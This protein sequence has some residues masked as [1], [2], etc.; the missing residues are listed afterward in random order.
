MND[1][2]NP[3]E[4][5][6]HLRRTQTSTEELMWQWLR[7]RQVAGAK[8]RRQ[9]PIGPYVA[10]FYCEQSKLVI[11]CDGKDHFTEEGANR[12]A[13]RDQYLRERGLT[14]FRFTNQEIE[15]DA[16]KV[17]ES[18]AGWLTKNPSPPA[19]SDENAEK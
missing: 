12:D 15:E 1:E 11:E 13:T 2:M 10:D 5:S 14:V 6:R 9:H 8:F 4:F 7:N 19:W 16:Q 3:L 18:I 17:I